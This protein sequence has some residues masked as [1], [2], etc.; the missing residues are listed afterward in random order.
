MPIALTPSVFTSPGAAGDFSWMLRQSRWARTLFVFNDNEQQ[1]RAFLARV[2]S[3][4]LDPAS[5]ACRAGGGNAVIRP[6]QCQQPPRAAGVPTGPGYTCLTDH[7]RARIDAAIAHIDVV[8]TSGDFSEVVYSASRTDPT[9]L[10]HGIFE[11]GDEVLRYIP[12][13]LAQLVDRIN[14]RQG[15]Q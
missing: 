3:G 13:E 2:G 15:A 5:P 4:T 1:S 14:R 11:V 6:F 9:V 12:A 10:G 7:A 8:L